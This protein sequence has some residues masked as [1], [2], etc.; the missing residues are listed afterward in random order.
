MIILGTAQEIDLN[1]QAVN[2]SLFSC[3]FPA[4]EHRERDSKLQS[5]QTLDFSM[6]LP[7]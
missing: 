4:E 6:A 7:S 5:V 3:L 2:E 1:C